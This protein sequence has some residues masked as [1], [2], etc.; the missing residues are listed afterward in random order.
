MRTQKRRLHRPYE[1]RSINL[2]HGMV[3]LT[4][5]MSGAHLVNNFLFGVTEKV[6][7]NIF[8]SLPFRASGYNYSTPEDSATKSDAVALN[9]VS[10]FPHRVLFVVESPC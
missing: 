4:M 3:I 10:H 1:P 8:N 7:N 5:G 2:P 6:A 9:I